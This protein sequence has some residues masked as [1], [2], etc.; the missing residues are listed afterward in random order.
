MEN[1]LE[2]LHLNEIKEC[3]NESYDKLMETF[4]EKS[5]EKSKLRNSSKDT[6]LVAFTKWLAS[7]KTKQAYS[8]TK[9]PLKDLKIHPQVINLK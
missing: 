2:P 9:W 5:Y 4:L 6:F 7:L 3:W 8:V 1:Q